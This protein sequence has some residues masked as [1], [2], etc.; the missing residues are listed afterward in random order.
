MN[1]T[2]FGHITYYLDIWMDAIF[3]DGNYYFEYYERSIA[4]W[5]KFRILIYWFKLLP[6]WLNCHVPSFFSICYVSFPSKTKLFDS[7]MKFEITLKKHVIWMCWFLGIKWNSEKF[8]APYFY[9]LKSCKNWV[10]NQCFFFKKTEPG[11]PNFYE[12]T[13]P[14][15]GACG[16]LL[17]DCYTN[18]SINSFR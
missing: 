4:T 12:K 14:K 16:G 6:K 18:L 1:T 17:T 8:S 3:Y 5:N 15:I 9:D 7:C 10:L 11:I 13:P 2:I